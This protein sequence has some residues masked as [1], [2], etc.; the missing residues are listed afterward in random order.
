MKE[1]YTIEFLNCEKNFQK[2]SVKF[3]GPQ[4]FEGAVLWGKKNLDNFHV[5]MIRVVF[6]DEN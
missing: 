2:D 1:Q 4:A 5:D 6:F 3:Q